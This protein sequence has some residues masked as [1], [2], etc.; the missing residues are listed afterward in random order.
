MRHVLLSSLLAMAAITCSPV[1]AS[2]H[3]T[4][5]FYELSQDHAVRPDPCR[6]DKPAPAGSVDLSV[7]PHE[8]LRLVSHCPPG[9]PPT[10][11]NVTASIAAGPV[12]NLSWLI[13]DGVAHH[14]ELER[15]VA[16]GAFAVIQAS[17]TI[18]NVTDAAVSAGVLY[19]YR[20]RSVDAA[21][22]KSPYSNV[23]NVATGDSIDTAPPTVPPSSP[24]W[25][26]SGST[27]DRRRG[28]RA[29]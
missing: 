25:P 19:H 26:S 2:T 23:V 15:S 10:P 8:Y 7:A 11:V 28:H 16:N 3:E 5:L 9:A 22:K 4:E 24:R 1:S 14:F 27:R 18:L 17:V 12:I 29:A 6:H 20:V 13:Y 21:G